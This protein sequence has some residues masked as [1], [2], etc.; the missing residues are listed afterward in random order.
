MEWEWLADVFPGDNCQTTQQIVLVS[1]LLLIC[2]EK[3][4]RVGQHLS[5]LVSRMAA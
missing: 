1:R 2:H 4:L 3:I 5:C